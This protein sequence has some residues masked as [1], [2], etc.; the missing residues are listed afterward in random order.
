M[1]SVRLLFLALCLLASAAFAQ[2]PSASLRPSTADEQRLDAAVFESFDD[3][4]GNR[5]ADI[6]SV[7][8]LV[9]GR[10]AYQYHR[11][12]RPEALRDTQSVAK[13]ALAALVGV[14]LRQGRIPSLDAAVVDLVPEWRALNADPRAGATRCG[15][16]SR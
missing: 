12:G 10:V 9:Q 13:S 5:L 8:V 16:C 11:D 2:Q 6:Q 4:I 3:V 14:A 7:V 15:T 1:K